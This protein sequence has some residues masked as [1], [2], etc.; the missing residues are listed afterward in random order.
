M[1]PEIIN[2]QLSTCLLTVTLTILCIVSIKLIF[3]N[4][5]LS[6]TITSS[7]FS[8][9]ISISY[10]LMDAPDVAMTEVA[11]GSCLSSCVFLS[12]LNRLPKPHRHDLKHTRLIS[13]SIICL[14]FIIILPYAGFNLPEYGSTDSPLQNHLTKYYI[15]NTQQDIGIPSFITALL[16]SYRG[17]DTLGET[18]VI[19]I[20]G[21]SVLLLFSKKLEKD[22][23]A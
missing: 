4:S 22:R 7:V 13:S 12:F 5:L 10:L 8:L 9:L 1:I 15:E 21:I 14:I 17:Y 18:I 19:L 6:L 11:L 16:A 20:A 23:D 3:C 2:F